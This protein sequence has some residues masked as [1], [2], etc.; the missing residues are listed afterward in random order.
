MLFKK[1]NNP[2]PDKEDQV[3]DEESDFYSEDDD[4]L[5]YDDNY[6]EG[7]RRNNVNRPPT[8]R[9]IFNPR[10][11]RKNGVFIPMPFHV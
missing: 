9:Q 7:P 3:E 2:L 1:R 11:P 6:D 4:E 5:D 8:I 10:K